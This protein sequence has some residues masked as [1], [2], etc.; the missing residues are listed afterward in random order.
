[1]LASRNEPKTIESLNKQIAEQE[2]RIHSLI[3]QVESLKSE[4][5]VL[6]QSA[7]TLTRL[8]AEVASE[9]AKDLHGKLQAEWEELRR[10]PVS[11][12]IVDRMNAILL[13]IKIVRGSEI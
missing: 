5:I 13:Q 11:Q 9:V 7:D 2:A 4:K 1:L 6:Q 12:E 10:A 3:E 8:Q